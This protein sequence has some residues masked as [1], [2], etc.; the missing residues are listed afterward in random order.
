MYETEKKFTP[1]VKAYRN[2]EFL[3]SP[4]GRLVRIIC[5]YEETMLR[6]KMHDITATVLIFGSARSKTHEEFEAAQ[7][8]LNAKVHDAKMSNDDELLQTANKELL[9]LNKTKWMVEMT[10]KVET[11]GR[12]LTE[13]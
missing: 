1:T 3:N 12:L 13:W 7:E 4:Q 2:P 5:E 9:K 11:L 6:L 8:K 10:D